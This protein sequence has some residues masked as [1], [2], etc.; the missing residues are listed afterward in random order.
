MCEESVDKTCQVAGH[1]LDGFGRSPARTQI[2]VARPQ[3]TVAAQQRRSGHAQDRRHPVTVSLASVPDQFPPADIP[4]RAQVEPR[5]EV[6]LGGPMN[7]QVS[8]QLGNDRLHGHHINTGNPGRVHPADPRQLCRQVK[9]PGRILAWSLPVLSLLLFPRRSARFRS[10]PRGC[11]VRRFAGRDRPSGQRPQIDLQLP[12]ACG[13]LSLLKLV[14]FDRLSQFKQQVLLPIAFQTA[15][16]F[17]FTG[18]DAAVPQ[19]C[20]FVSIPFPAQNGPNDCLSRY[21]A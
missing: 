8:P 20:Q 9:R 19:R 17:L 1:C 3:I 21:A 12:V 15:G 10:F 14:S 7:L 11:S 5:C 16:D 13:Q 6:I 2:S 18:R 4:F